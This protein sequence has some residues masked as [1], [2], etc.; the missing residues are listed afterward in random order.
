VSPAL[1]IR[2][3]RRFFERP[4]A[5]ASAGLVCLLLATL[6]T[7]V[8]DSVVGDPEDFARLERA[9]FSEPL[10]VGNLENTALSETSGL[11]SSRL[12]DDLL[13]AVNDSGNGPVLYAIG[14]DGR[15][16]GSVRVEGAE[17]RDWEDIASFLWQD[18]ASGTL[19][20]YLVVADTGDNLSKRDTLS[21]YGI[22]E[23]VLKG[24]R[25]PAGS[26]APIA[27]RQTFRFEDGP[28]DSEGIAVDVSGGRILIVSKRN[29]PAEVYSLALPQ[30]FLA[31]T[32]P[33]S[34]ASNPVGRATGGAAGQEVEVATRIALLSG[35]PRPTQADLEESPKY[36]AHRSQP[37]AFDISPDGR[38]AVILT[39]KH[40]YYFSRAKGESW[41]TAFARDP[42]R[43]AVPPMSQTEAGAFARDGQ[44]FFATTE[45]RPAP[46][47]K[48][49]RE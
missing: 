43:L 35:I 36:G 13:W 7:A 6:S 32:S 12:Q 45:D 15:D 26:V 37:T 30:R 16:R 10:Y 5:F 49:P 3:L 42:Q 14:A 34:A 17:N 41:R 2:R 28:R 11:A 38:D 24:E 48:I 23:P 40:A 18:E 21:F 25:L 8:S 4:F 19:R 20:A 46:L 1:G 47:F 31:P 22:E 27:W 39:Y 33:H 44:S 29:V 9:P